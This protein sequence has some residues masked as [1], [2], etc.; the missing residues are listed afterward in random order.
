MSNANPYLSRHS[1]EGQQS[2]TKKLFSGIATG[3]FRKEPIDSQKSPC[4]T[5]RRVV[6]SLRGP[7]QSPALPF[8]CCVGSLR[9]V[10][11]CGRCSCWCRF[12]VRGATSL[13]CRGCAEC[14]GM[15]RLRPPPPP[16]Q[17]ISHPE[18]PRPRGQRLEW[19]TYTRARPEHTR[20]TRIRATSTPTHTHRSS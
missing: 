6:V 12:R 3:A 11:R 2:Q 1:A 5:F 20:V 4:V 17:T 19:L 13:V 16:P 7:G 15:C 9:S 8:A 14:G 18:S 10:G